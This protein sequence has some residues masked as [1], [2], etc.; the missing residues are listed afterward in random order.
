[1]A[2]QTATILVS[3]LVGSTALRVDLGEERAETVR[4][5]HD[6][7]LI[8]AAQANGGTVVKGLGDGVLVMFAGAAEAVAAAVAM[9]RSV[10]LHARNEKL[11]LAIRAP[12]LPVGSVVPSSSAA[13]MI[14]ALPLLSNTVSG[15]ADRVTRSVAAFR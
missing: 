12:L 1:M 4:R 15:P 8:D 3:D 11:A 13:W 10:D 7:S 14:R 9:Q 6:R 2:T 5:E